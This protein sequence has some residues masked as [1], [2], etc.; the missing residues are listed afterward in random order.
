MSEDKHKGERIAKVMARAGLCSRRDA[1]KWIAASRV[2]VNGKVIDSPALNVSGS[3]KVVVDGK[4]LPDKQN[5]R[6]F[7]YHK[8][9]GLVTSHKDEQGRSTVFDNLPEYLPRVISVGRLDLN[10]EGL[11]LLTND[12]ELARFLE[13][14]STGW[15]RRYRV[16]V[17]GKVNEKRLN[18]LK[19][20]IIVEDVRYKSIEAKLGKIPEDEKQKNAGS[21]GAN[22]WLSISL[23]EGK[24]REIRRVMEALGLRVTRLIRT[25]YGPFSLGNVTRGT[26]TEVKP[27][28]MKHQVAKYFAGNKAQKGKNR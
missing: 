14:P 9:P 13:L 25:D 1:E 24:N 19:N 12:G 6:L 8:P 2:K 26:V 3:D 23:R 4:A 17:H 11:L 15:Q 22:S 21:G 28:V 20:G 7:L 18:S 10:T 5:A 27:D 16:R